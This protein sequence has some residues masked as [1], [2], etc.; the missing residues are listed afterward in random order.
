MPRVQVAIAEDN[1]G[2]VTEVFLGI[3]SS[4]EV[5][6]P[7]VLGSEAESFLAV[8]GVLLIV[9][10]VWEEHI[11]NSVLSNGHGHLVAGKDRPS[12]GIQASFCLVL[13]IVAR[14]HS[15]SVVIIHL[16]SSIQGSQV[17]II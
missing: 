3:P 5:Q 6:G 9:P 11:S 15:S 16:H 8:L 12:T 13:N 1:V 17:V 7:L 4:E 2:V 14:H 10:G